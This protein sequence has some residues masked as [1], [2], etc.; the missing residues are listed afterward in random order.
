LQQELTVPN[1][2]YRW[3]EDRAAN[4]YLGYL[5]LADQLVVSGESMSMLAEAGFTGKPLY[6][7]DP[8]DTGSWWRYAHNYRYKP[9]THRLAMLLAP[10]R[11]HR[12]V[13]N[14]QRQ[15]VSS[16]RA[17]WLGQQ[18]PQ[19]QLHGPPDDVKRAAVRVRALF[20]E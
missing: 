20:S 8:A 18:F 13:G 2:V 6:I 7:Y 11:M 10:R 14:I 17:V 4:P 19:G 16:G 1:T 9:L 3:S 12:D 5:A 15:L